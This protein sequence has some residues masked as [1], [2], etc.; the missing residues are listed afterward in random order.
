VSV[1]TYPVLAA[2][3]DDVVLGAAIVLPDHPQLEPE[4]LGDAER[5]EIDAHNPAVREMVAGD[6]PAVAAGPKWRGSS[7]E[8]A[9]RPELPDGV[10]ETARLAG[11]PRPWA[12]STTTRSRP[13]P[14]GSGSASRACARQSA[15]TPSGR[16]RAGPRARWPGRRSCGTGAGA[17][18][19]CGSRSPR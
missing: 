2:P 10:D 16:A 13:W 5:A 19:G 3:A 4:G 15:A 9:T 8:P 11:A 7:S 18:C 6:P 14:P 1:N 12:P 17:A